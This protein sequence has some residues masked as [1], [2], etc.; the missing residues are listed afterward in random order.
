MKTSDLYKKTT[1]TFTHIKMQ[2][3]EA[4]VPWW[5]KREHSIHSQTK[6]ITFLTWGPVDVATSAFMF[7]S[8]ARNSIFDDKN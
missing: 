2:D 8:A 1:H 6:Y 7:Y 4:A 5:K 3:T